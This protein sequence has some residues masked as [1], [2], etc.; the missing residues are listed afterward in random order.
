MLVR[1]SSVAG[2]S[3]RD[4][5]GRR[6]K[7]PPVRP[8]IRTTLG[9]SCKGRP[10]RLPPVVKGGAHPA[11]LVSCNPLFYGAV[12]HGMLPSFKIGTTSLQILSETLE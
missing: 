1:L 12:L 9:F 6:Y 8:S 5:G 11:D 4:R 7:D 3:F 2:M 10:Q